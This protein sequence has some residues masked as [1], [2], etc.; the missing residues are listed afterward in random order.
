LNGVEGGKID[1]SSN[2]HRYEK[3]ILVSSW[4]MGVTNA[5][6]IAETGGLSA[7]K[8]QHQDAHFTTEDQKAVKQFQHRVQTGLHAKEAVFVALRFDGDSNRGEFLRYKFSDCIL[9]PIRVSGGGKEPLIAQFSL[10]FATIE[11]VYGAANQHAEVEPRHAHLIRNADQNSR[12]V[13]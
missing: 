9:G 7:G 3:W 6:Q 10:N 2:I 1:G 11:L 5:V 13:A 12:A 8:S 4:S